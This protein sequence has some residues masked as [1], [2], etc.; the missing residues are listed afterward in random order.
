M[1]RLEKGLWVLG[2]PKRAQVLASC[3]IIAEKWALKSAQSA[4]T[5][6]RAHAMGRL[7][8]PQ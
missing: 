6:A 7:E 4:P 3:G 5:R 1:K 8:S 2:V